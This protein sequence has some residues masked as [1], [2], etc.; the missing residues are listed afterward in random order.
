MA[1][2]QQYIVLYNLFFIL[3]ISLSHNQFTWLYSDFLL[4]FFSLFPVIFSWSHY[5]FPILL[6]LA[7]VSTINT[8]SHFIVWL[9]GLLSILAS[10]LPLAEILELLSFRLIIALSLSSSLLKIY[11]LLEGIYTTRWSSHYQLESL[12]PWQWGTSRLERIWASNRHKGK[13]S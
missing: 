10:L 6:C 9:K 2:I 7:P 3:F 12:F 1:T 11:M 13:T 4:V 5:K 8:G